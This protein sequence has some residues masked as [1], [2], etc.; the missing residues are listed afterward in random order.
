MIT[1]G[2]S[3]LSSIKY[4][5]QNITAVYA[6]DT[7]IWPTTPP[8]WI[9]KNFDGGTLANGRDVFKIKNADNTTSIYYSGYDQSVWKNFELVN[10]SWA[11]KTW[12]FS[13]TISHIEGNY[14][15]TDKNGKYRYSH[16]SGSTTVNEGV[17]NDGNSWGS[18][19]WT[20]IGGPT[21]TFS[22]EGDSAF[23]YN[24]DVYIYG[25]GRWFKQTGDTT[26]TGMTDMK[27]TSITYGPVWEHN[28]HYY[29]CN[30]QGSWELVNGVWTN[31]VWGGLFPQYPHSSEIW[32]HDGH[33]YY[34]SGE[35]QLELIGNVWVEKEW[36][37]IPNIYLFGED[38]WSDNNGNVYCTYARKTYQLDHI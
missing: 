25:G 13:G 32:K 19:Y 37:G 34:S 18:G 27:G 9:P 33:V 2:N 7:L 4:G 23:T 16:M 17:L 6:G 38:I 11:T 31:K 5:N 28:G 24:G 21:G 30:A 3:N 35:T 14:I 22:F 26:L 36:T 15:W 1:I 29:M 10:G 20:V 12:N 8:N